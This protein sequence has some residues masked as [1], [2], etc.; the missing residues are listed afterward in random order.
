MLRGLGISFLEKPF[1][2]KRKIVARKVTHL[3]PDR[4]QLSRR[5]QQDAYRGDGSFVLRTDE[6]LRAFVELKSA[7]H[8]RRTRIAGFKPRFATP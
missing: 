3:L 1:W 4:I 7:P 6:K 8:R 2:E 5:Y